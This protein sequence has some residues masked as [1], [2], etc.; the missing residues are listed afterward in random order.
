MTTDGSDLGLS[1]DPASRALW[2]EEENVE[3]I[4]FDIE[5]ELQ[6]VVFSVAGAGADGKDQLW[7][8][9]MNDPSNTT[10]A[11]LKLD[12]VFNIDHIAMYPDEQTVFYSHTTDQTLNSPVI[13]RIQYDS[14][15]KATAVPAVPDGNGNTSVTCLTMDSAAAK[16]VVGREGSFEYYDWTDSGELEKSK[17]ILDDGAAGIPSTCCC[18]AESGKLWFFSYVA[19][20]S[21]T[22][23]ALQYTTYDGAAPEV[24]WRADSS[25]QTIGSLTLDKTSSL[26]D[27]WSMKAVW[28]VKEAG[29]AG[30][31]FWAGGKD[32]GKQIFES[33]TLEAVA[34]GSDSAFLLFVPFTMLLVSGAIAATC[35]IGLLLF[36]CGL[37]TGGSN[38]DRYGR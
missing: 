28:T 24:W 34:V 13:S 8:K 37:C 5:T 29:A 20:S 3:V 14:A 38:R 7:I 32:Q 36:C 19:Q 22:E 35:L 17:T 23:L 2:T 11:V 31:L 9:P 30:K 26:F 25:L 27:P 18:A 4:D 33:Q 6:P 15:A 12:E 21:G 16:L 10:T 1:S